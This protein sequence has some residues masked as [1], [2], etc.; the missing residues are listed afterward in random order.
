MSVSQ[1][2]IQWLMFGILYWC[3]SGQWGYQLKILLALP[4]DDTDDH[5]D[6]DGHDD[7]DDYDDH[8]SDKSYLVKK[9]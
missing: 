7:H 3:D 9:L 4:S 1:S 6:H 8:D 2:V 5:D